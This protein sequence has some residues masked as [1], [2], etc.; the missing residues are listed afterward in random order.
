MVSDFEILTSTTVSGN[1][2]VN[3]NAVYSADIYTDVGGVP[4]TLL[5][6]LA[7]PGTAQFLFVGRDPA[8][9]PLG[10]FVTQLTDF[11]FSGELNG[12]TFD[13]K[14]NTANTSAGSTTILQATLDPVT[15][16]VSGTL[17]IFALYSFNGSP[18]MPG[19][20]SNG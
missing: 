1:Q 9:N 4:G 3:V 20:A 8:V 14:R 18:F 11:S 5:G 15:Y 16:E 17:E 10:T 19:P 6:H 12:N 7:I 13:V 2:V